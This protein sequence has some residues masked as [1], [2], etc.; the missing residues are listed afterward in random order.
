MVTKPCCEKAFG[1]GVHEC[2]YEYEYK[3][4]EIQGSLT[5]GLRSIV[6]FVGSRRREN[7]YNRY[8][9]TINKC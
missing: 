2:E 5:L 7:F 6:T 4:M 8:G 9:P 3:C 1:R